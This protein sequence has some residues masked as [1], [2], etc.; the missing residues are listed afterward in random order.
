[1]KKGLVFLLLFSFLFGKHIKVQLNWLYQFEFAGYIVA[2]EKGF[3]KEK[4]LKVDLIEY[5][6]N[7]NVI[8]QVLSKKADFGVE[9]IDVF[10][11]YLLGKPLVGLAAIYQDSPH[12]L[13]SIKEYNKTKLSDL[14]K[15]AL[16]YG[17]QIPVDFV[18]MFLSEHV[19]FDKLQL[20]KVSFNVDDLIKRKFD[21]ITVFISNEPYRLRKK[22]FTPVIFSPKD[23][24]FHFYSGILFTSKDF[25]K[26]NPQVV[27]DFLDATLKGWE[28][29]FNHIDET[30]DLIYKKYN[31]L[32]KTKDELKYEALVLK[33]LALKGEFGKIDVE[34][35]EEIKNYY[36]ILGFNA[37]SDVEGFI[38]DFKKFFLSDAEREYIRKNPIINICIDPYWAPIEYLEKNKYKGISKE[39]LEIIHRKT[40][41]NFHL[42]R[43]KNWEESLKF[44]KSKKCILLPAAAI[45][46][47]RKKFAIFT[48]P[49]LNYELAFITRE[50][51]PFIRSIKDVEDKLLARQKGSGLIDLLKKRY[52]NIKFYL[53]DS[54]YEAFKAVADK[55]A[56]Y[57]LAIL[58][59]ASYFN[60]KY[61]LNL[62]VAGYSDIDYRLAMMIDKNHKILKSILTKALNTIDDSEIDKITRKYVYKVIDK[63][64]VDKR[65]IYLLFFVFVV[66][67]FLVLILVSRQ[68]FLKRMNIE[69]KR[70]VKEEIKKRLSLIL[71]DKLT[72]CYSLAKFKQDAKNK[73]FKYAIMLN[74]RNFSKIN[75]V[76]GFKMGDEVLKAVCEKL[77]SFKEVYR[78]DADEFVF[79]SDDY[80]KD[81]KK[82]NELFKEEICVKEYFFK[83]GFYFGITK[84]S[85]DILKY[86]SIAVKKAKKAGG[87]YF[88]FEKEDE[89][90]K[91][92]LEFNKYLFRAIKGDKEIL[93]VPFFQG[94]SDG[95]K[96]IK[97]ESLARLIIKGD[98]YTPYYFLDIARA[99]GFLVDLT[100]IILEK[101]FKVARDC[102]IDVSINLS[103]EDLIRKDIVEFIETLREKYN[104]S[105]SRITFEILENIENREIIKHIQTLKEL[106]SLG[107][108]IAI[109]DFGV[110][111]SNFEKILDLDIN[112][113]KIDAKYVKNVLE[114]KRSQ[115]IIESIVGFAHKLGI[116]V[117]AEFVENKEIYKKLKEIG[118]DYFQGYYFS[119][120]EQKECN[121]E[122]SKNG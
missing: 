27:D 114:D 55:K 93:L 122:K 39:I 120:P 10:K 69:L 104:L 50:D 15:I 52:P 64:V 65:L 78:L 13:M 63:S 42:I 92:F 8:N 37:K 113:V 80:F 100:N 40:G 102:C 95:N 121:E 31:S 44:F 96:I 58:P 71:E 70:K 24:G 11:E 103:N 45:T 57:T 5:N 106:K 66:F 49:Y 32:H 19:D 111:N 77:K 18:L 72:G 87:Y 17:D 85:P 81:I 16:K 53:T 12:A 36:R 3:Y 34:R 54:V 117:I 99:S 43:T 4:G 108:K 51:V 97:Y 56:Y 62:H 61:L 79:F 6:P 1:M 86:L 109:D 9:E 101:S 14:K 47:K 118:V 46:D 98:V 25:A 75:S 115:I 7:I 112:Y 22:G 116:K 21:A 110:E 76:Y 107:Y 38:F 105:S 29:A 119:K 20:Y 60:Y 67:M 23:Y 26:T 90:A 82:I 94:I 33:K 28:W 89:E 74:I 2:K 30:V 88:F 84:K 35:L 41:L 59:V 73:H 48:Q 91:K 68:R 83:I